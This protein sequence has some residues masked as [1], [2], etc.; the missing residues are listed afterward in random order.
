MDEDRDEFEKKD[1]G[2]ADIL[3]DLFD[4][5]MKAVLEKGILEYNNK[6]PETT[7]EQFILPK[8][9]ITKKGENPES[10]DVEL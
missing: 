8:E 10:D 9:R 2:G 7:M 1:N 6:E 4:K 3:F 5:K